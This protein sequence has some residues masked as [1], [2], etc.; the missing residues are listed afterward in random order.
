MEE[1]NN[2]LYKLWFLQAIEAPHK[3][4]SQNSKIYFG[5]VD[6]KAKIF[7]ILYAPFENSTTRTAITEEDGGGGKKGKATHAGSLE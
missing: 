1:W 6:S 5:Y 3:S 2:Q 7:L 4:N